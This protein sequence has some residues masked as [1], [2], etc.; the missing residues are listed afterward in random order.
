MYREVPDALQIVVTLACSL[1]KARH[2]LV[3]EEGLLAWL[4]TE[5]SF[6]PHVG[7]GYRL[8]LAHDGATAIEGRI[9][10]YDPSSGIAYTVSDEFLKKAFGETIAKWAWEPL[11]GDYTLIT[12]THTGYGQGDAWQRAFEGHIRSWTFFLANLV[13]VANEG[14]DQRG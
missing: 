11:S 1:Q 4:A 9:H 2:F 7:A 8:D 14:K 3:T 12:L 13:S 6:T 10:G 5:A